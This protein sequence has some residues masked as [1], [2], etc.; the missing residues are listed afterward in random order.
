MYSLFSFH[1]VQSNL[2]CFHMCAITS[3]LLFKP[4]TGLRVV[5]LHGQRVIQPEHALLREQEGL[6]LVGP[7]PVP[8]CQASSR[9]LCL[10]HLREQPIRHRR[11]IP[12]S[13]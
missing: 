8:H 5:V 6:N 13:H 2:S 10:G 4:L 7:W 1:A 12:R 11:L 9:L 3:H